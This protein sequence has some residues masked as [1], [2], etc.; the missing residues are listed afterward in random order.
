M[1]VLIGTPVLSSSQLFT[2]GPKFIVACTHG[3]SR[4]NDKAPCLHTVILIWLFISLMQ[5]SLSCY[6]GRRLTCSRQQQRHTC[7]RTPT[8]GGYPDYHLFCGFCLVVDSG[9]IR[10]TRPFQP[11]GFFLGNNHKS[12]K[13]WLNNKVWNF[14]LF[15]IVFCT[16]FCVCSGLDTQLDG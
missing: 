2:S 6:A 11:D 9:E 7:T 8:A 10:L 14:W 15:D 3:R 16:R 5:P 4:V 13:H 12:F 1:T